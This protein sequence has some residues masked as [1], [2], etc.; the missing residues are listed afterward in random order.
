[1]YYM[2][3][4]LKSIVNVYSRSENL[5]RNVALTIILSSELF[6]NSALGDIVAT[7]IMYH[8][9]ETANS[10]TDEPGE[11]I[12]LF[13]TTDQLLD[14]SGYNFDRGITYTFPPDSA[15]QALSYIV[16]AKNPQLI[17]NQYGIIDVYGPFEGALS[18][19]GETVRLLDPNAQTIFSFRY[20]THGDWPAAPDGTGHSLVFPDLN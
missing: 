16:I 6:I 9:A 1:M 7:E 19:S 10:E 13:N 15:I 18:N 11:F 17:Q 20:G 14:I 4:I 8:P 5:F 2:L 12:E 3:I